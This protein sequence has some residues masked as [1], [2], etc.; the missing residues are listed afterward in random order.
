MSNLVTW[1]VQFGHLGCLT[2]VYEVFNGE[3]E[4]SKIETF[5]V[6]FGNLGCLKAETQ[7]NIY[8]F[9]FP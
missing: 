5:G 9:I 4:V 8:G 6:L 7:G 1:G 3:T 2:G